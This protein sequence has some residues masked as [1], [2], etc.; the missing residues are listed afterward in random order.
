[1]EQ[2]SYIHDFDCFTFYYNVIQSKLTEAQQHLKKLELYKSTIESFSLY[3]LNDMSDMYEEQNDFIT[4]VHKQCAAWRTQ[5]LSLT[6]QN[7]IN[8]LGKMT[9]HLENTIYHILF[10]IEQIQKQK[11]RLLHEHDMAEILDVSHASYA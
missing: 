10:L 3:R 6:Q 9:Q 1:M 8:E 2:K 7:K 5:Q 11:E 4:I